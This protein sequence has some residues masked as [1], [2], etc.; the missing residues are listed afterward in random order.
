MKRVAQSGHI[1]WIVLHLEQDAVRG[2]VG[3]F[4]RGQPVDLGEAGEGGLPGFPGTNDPVQALL[5]HFFA[6]QYMKSVPSPVPAADEFWLNQV[7]SLNNVL[8]L[9]SK[10]ARFAA[11]SMAIPSRTP[12]SSGLY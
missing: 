3:H 7:P 4:L 5:G 11:G 6:F 1:V 8:A 9:S 10:K 12:T 2:R